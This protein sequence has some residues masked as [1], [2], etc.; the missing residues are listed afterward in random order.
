MSGFFEWAFKA[1][2]LLEV[3]IPVVLFALVL[4]VGGVI[5]AWK[6]LRGVGR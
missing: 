2:L 1:W 5:L 3:V 6:W 4:V